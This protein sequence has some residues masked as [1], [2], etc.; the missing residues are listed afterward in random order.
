MSDTLEWIAD[1]EW[2]NYAATAETARVTPGLDLVMREDLVLTSSTLLPIPD[3]NHA[4]L[5]RTGEAQAEDLIKEVESYYRGRDL[6]PTIYLSPACRPRSLI[7][8]LK[9]RGFAPQP[10]REAWMVL[11]DLGD[12]AIPSPTPKVSVE[13]ISKS[14]A[15]TFARVFLT[16]FGMPPEFTPALAELLRPSVGLPNVRHYLAY[17]DDE[18][19]GTCSLLTHDRFGV[20]GS[21]GV[22]RSRR[23][24]GA[25]T[26]LAIA[27]IQDA[28]QKQ[29]V[30][31]L[32]LQTAADTLLERFLRINGFRRAFTRTCYIQSD[33]QAG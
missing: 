4:C 3:A 8:H 30:Q 31:T 1:L 20:L 11:D 26:N 19:V 12:F 29:G 33:D 9:C 15:E 2:A 13:T 18:A 16:A 10:D 23:S 27:A 28:V 22:I 17:T 25:A 21:V 7:H 6:A 24:R 14:D 32:M 5:L